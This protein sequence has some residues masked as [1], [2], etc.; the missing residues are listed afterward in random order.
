MKDNWLNHNTDKI[1][2]FI[3]TVLLGLMII[4]VIHHGAS[5]DKLLAWAEN[6]FDTVLGAL[7]MVLTGRIARSDGQTANGLPPTTPNNNPQPLSPISPSPSTV[8]QSG[9]LKINVP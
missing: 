7:I 2:L 3:L 5:D 8:D 4:H 1:L 6:T 9:K